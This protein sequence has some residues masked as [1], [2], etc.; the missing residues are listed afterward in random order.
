VILG[1][2]VL[3]KRYRTHFRLV[4]ADL[5]DAAYICALR[6]DPTL[7]RHLS[8]SASEA[9]A[10]LRWLEQ[11]KS[12]EQ[13]G[14]E[15]YFVI[16]CDGAD[17]GVVRMY[18]FREIE[19]RRSFCWGSWIIPPP[20]TPGLATCSA[21]LIYEAGFETLGFEQSHF[22]VRLANRGVI[23]FHERAGARRVSQDE[24]DAFFWFLPEDYRRM[25]AANAARL[26]EHR[27]V[28]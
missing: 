8:P 22:D 25:R 17:R 12:R 27:V 1:S 9:S 26:A 19:G 10:Q 7:N 16:V 23:A 14:E 4:N 11:Y 28:V 15:Y 5:A 2:P 24:Q 20:K 21:L 6:A 13:A 3:D 18:D